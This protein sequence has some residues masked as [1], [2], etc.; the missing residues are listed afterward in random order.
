MTGLSWY[1]YMHYWYKKDVL[2]GMFQ[3]D[4]K[5]QNSQQSHEADSCKDDDAEYDDKMFNRRL[6]SSRM[7]TFWSQTIKRSRATTME[8][9]GDVEIGGPDRHGRGP[10][11][12]L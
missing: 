9:S 1:F 3:L 12:G 5:P 6:G 2:S 11:N 10:R 4:L 8:V 7:A